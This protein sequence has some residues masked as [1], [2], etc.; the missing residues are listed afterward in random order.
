MDAFQKT[1][2]RITF[3]EAATIAAEKGVRPARVVGTTVLRFVKARTP[4]NLEE[5]GW[6]EFER[7]AKERGVAVFESAGWMR[8]MRDREEG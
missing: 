3:Q 5:I 8:I 4:G 1:M 6:E 2:R 7:I